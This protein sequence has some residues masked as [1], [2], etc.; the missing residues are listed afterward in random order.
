[1][2]AEPVKTVGLAVSATVRR[3]DDATI[4]LR[5]DGYAR[6]GKELDEN[7]RTRPESRGC[8]LRVL[9]EVRYDR[10]KQ[11][12]E[13]F[14]VAG[15][16]RAWGTK[17]DYINREIRSA[18]RGSRRRSGS[19]RPAPP[20]PR[21]GCGAERAGAADAPPSLRR[22]LAARPGSPVL[23]YR[24]EPGNRFLYRCEADGTEAR[25]AVSGSRR[26][27]SPGAIPVEL[28]TSA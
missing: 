24:P 13:R 19:P 5:L 18:G 25:L 20:G 12:I 8:E 23:R 28:Q 4:V 27:T 16:G 3:A 22:L 9:G 7:L 17:M 11:A 26:G 6:L 14:D 21:R 10:K 15:V 1:M 2:F